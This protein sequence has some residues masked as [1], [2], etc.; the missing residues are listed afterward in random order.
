MSF[1]RKQIRRARDTLQFRMPDA[2]RRDLD[3]AA[4]RIGPY[5]VRVAQSIVAVDTGRTRAAITYRVVTRRTE[6]A[7]WT[8]LLIVEI[9]T[10]TRNDIFA[11]FVTEFGRGQGRSGARARGRLP[12]RPFLRPSRVLAGKRARGA[13]SR[14]MRTA[15]RAAFN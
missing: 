12:P 1:D 2:L 14:A 13:F 3:K 15:A 7:G 9:P 4:H 5:G 8:Y 10:L 11:S 6:R